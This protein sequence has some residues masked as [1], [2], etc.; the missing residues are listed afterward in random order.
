MSLVSVK[1]ETVLSLENE[2]TDSI[3]KAL[4]NIGE[5]KDVRV[6]VVP[7]DSGD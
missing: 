7:F 3:R 1:I 2:V 6:T 4:K 5:I